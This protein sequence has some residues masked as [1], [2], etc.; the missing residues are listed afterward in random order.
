MTATT[1]QAAG[2]EGL[3]HLLAHADLDAT[4]VGPPVAV[5]QPG[6]QRAGARARI[7]QAR[8]IDQRIQRRHQQRAERR[9]REAPVAP[10]Q[11]G[12]QCHQLAPSLP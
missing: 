7:P 9:Q 4:V 10:Q 2:N 6:T 12:V 8:Q 11:R 1:G 5:D 3:L